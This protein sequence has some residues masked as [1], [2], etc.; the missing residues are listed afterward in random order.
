MQGKHAKVLS[1]TQ[2]RASVRYLD[3]TPS[4]AREWAMVLLSIKAGLRPKKS[5]PFNSMECEPAGGETGPLHSNPLDS[6]RLL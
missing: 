6:S 3:T 2:E 4:P 1:P 5:R